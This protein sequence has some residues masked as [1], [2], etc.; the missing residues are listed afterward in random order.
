MKYDQTLHFF[1]LLNTISVVIVRSPYTLPSESKSKVTRKRNHHQCLTH[2]HDYLAC[3]GLFI[4]PDEELTICMRKNHHSLIPHC[5]LLL[6]TSSHVGIKLYGEEGKSG[7]RH[8]ARLG[9]FQRNSE[10]SFLVATDHPLGILHKVHVWHDN[11]GKHPSWYVSRVVVRDLL[12]NRKYYFLVNSW[13][14]LTIE[15]GSLDK[16]V[17]AAGEWLG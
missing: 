6:G 3:M 17:Y 13:M 2:F 5:L 14:S 1:I 10:D 16:Q 11:T 9:A 8:L 4:I 15:R 12:A 7:A